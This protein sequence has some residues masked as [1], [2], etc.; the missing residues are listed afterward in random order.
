MHASKGAIILKYMRLLRAGS[1]NEVSQDTR[2]VA[3]TINDDDENI[4]NEIGK[5][6]AYSS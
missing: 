5:L 1:S 6:N 4:R 3:S 2:I